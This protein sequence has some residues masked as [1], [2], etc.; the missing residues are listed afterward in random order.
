MGVNARASLSA[1]GVGKDACLNVK[2]DIEYIHTIHEMEKKAGLGVRNA[3]AG[4]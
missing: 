4:I 3:R 1:G 2:A